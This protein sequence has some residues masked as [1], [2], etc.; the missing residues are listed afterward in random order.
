MRPPR[1]ISL[2][3]DLRRWREQ[4]SSATP[5][6]ELRPRQHQ[7][8]VGVVERILLTPGASLKMRLSD[9]TGSVEAVWSQRAEL[10]GVTLGSALLLSATVAEGPNRRP[11]LRNPAW[12]PVA[13]P[14]SFPP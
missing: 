1:P 10:P 7:Q 14:F 11:L 12:T 2:D 4:F 3:A 6:D 5:I 9:G 8:L 13:E